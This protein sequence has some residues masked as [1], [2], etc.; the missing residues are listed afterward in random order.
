LQEI[1]ACGAR[2]AEPGVESMSARRMTGAIAK[3]ARCPGQSPGPATIRPSTIRNISGSRGARSQP[4]HPRFFPT[5][6]RAW[7]RCNFVVALISIVSRD[8]E[9]ATDRPY[10]RS[11]ADEASQRGRQGWGCRQRRWQKKNDPGALGQHHSKWSHLA[12]K[13][14]FLAQRAPV[15]NL[16][17]PLRAQA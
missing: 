12:P 10:H 2:H 15:L 16:V 17:A 5:L 9:L 13:A 11:D 6:Q 4:T 7:L 3:S 8:P 1:L 14:I